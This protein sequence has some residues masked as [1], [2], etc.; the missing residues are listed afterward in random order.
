[1]SIKFQQTTFIMVTTLL[2]KDETA[3]GKII[4]ETTLELQSD[5]VSVREVIEARVI[6][7]V[8]KYNSQAT[9]YF[10][11]LVQPSDAERTLNGFRMRDRRFVDPEKQVYVALDAFQKNSYFV[12]VDDHQVE[13]L[14]QEIHIRPNSSVSFVQ[15][16]PL[17]GG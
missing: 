15:L 10:N 3:T 2:V 7:E 11:G 8:E 14:S 12:L 9:E 5:R 6:A 4:T 13:S 1:L 16:V 17:V